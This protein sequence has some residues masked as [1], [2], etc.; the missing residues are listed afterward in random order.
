MKDILDADIIF[1][2]IDEPINRFCAS[3]H[4]APELFRNAGPESPATPTRFF[5]VKHRDMQG[6]YCEPCLIV[7]NYIAG[8]KKQGLL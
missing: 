5:M 8:L 1:E 4:E 6:I 2:Q 7:A 3:G